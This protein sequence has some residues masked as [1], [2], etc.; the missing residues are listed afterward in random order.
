MSSLAASQLEKLDTD[1][2]TAIHQQLASLRSATSPRWSRR[3]RQY[4]PGTRELVPITYLAAPYHQLSFTWN[5]AYR[6]GH[7]F[8]LNGSAGKGY[9]SPYSGT[10]TEWSAGLN[11]NRKWRSGWLATG[12]YYSRYKA[13]IEVE[14]EVAASGAGNTSQGT[15][16]Y[17]LFSQDTDL[18]TVTGNL[19]Q[20]L[21]RQFRL[22][23]SAHVSEGTVKDN[24]I[25]Y[26]YHDY[27]G[28]ATVTRPVGRST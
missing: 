3:S 10:S 15:P 11:Y 5:G 7:G 1:A 12:Y 24:G 6:L 18:D 17:S 27:G 25:P 20:N 16:T 23:T 4:Q 9:S 14:N 21:P 8:S 2:A 19:T 13:D 26:P 22:A 28:L